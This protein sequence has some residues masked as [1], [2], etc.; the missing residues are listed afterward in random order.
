MPKS[1]VF[2]LLFQIR[3]RSDLQFSEFDLWY[4]YNKVYLKLK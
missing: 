4:F 3:I 2:N 1:V